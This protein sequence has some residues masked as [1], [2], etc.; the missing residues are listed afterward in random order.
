MKLANVRRISVEKGASDPQPIEFPELNGDPTARGGFRHW[1]AFAA[2]YKSLI[3]SDSAVNLFFS[4][5][6]LLMTAILPSRHFI[7][8]CSLLLEGVR[9]AR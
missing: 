1:Y 4:A 6:N 3:G 2:N 9:A 5:R 7:C 8:Y